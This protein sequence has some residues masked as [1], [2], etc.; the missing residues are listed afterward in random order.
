MK[1]GVNDLLWDA[2][3]GQYRDNPDS[4]LHPQDGNSLAVWYGLAPRSRAARVSTALTT[5]WNS[6]GATTPEK[7]GEIGTFPGSMELNAHLQAGDATTALQLM[8][9]EWGY[10]L[11]SPMGTGSTFWEGYLADGQ[12]GYGGAYPTAPRR[13]S[14]PMYGRWTAYSPRTKSGIAASAT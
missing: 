14:L 7:G 8:R 6:Y 12:F 4:A 1:S 3:A 9:R 5:N 11:N 2:R 10:M 13:P